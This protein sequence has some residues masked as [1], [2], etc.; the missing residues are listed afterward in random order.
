MLALRKTGVSHTL[1]LNEKLLFVGAKKS[2]E[3][4]RERGDETDESGVHHHGR[5]I[6]GCSGPKMVEGTR[7]ARRRECIMG[8]G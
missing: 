5:R 2:L 6:T 1:H 8:D 7:G 3:S 4:R